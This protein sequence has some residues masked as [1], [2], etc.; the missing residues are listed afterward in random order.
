MSEV[1]TSPELFEAYTNGVTQYV[2]MVEP[3]DSS[4]DVLMIYDNTNDFQ[5]G[6][7]KI[8]SNGNN[9]TDGRA[10]MW[11]SLFDDIN[12]DNEIAIFG[13]SVWVEEY[14]EDIDGR[15]FSVTIQNRV[16]SYVLVG[17]SPPGENSRCAVFLYNEN[18]S[19]LYPLVV[20]R[21][22]DGLED[23]YWSA[24]NLNVE[25][26]NVAVELEFYVVSDDD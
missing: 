25:N 8:K 26:R 7:E 6:F 18:R 13:Y 5:K 2:D 9:K 16:E 19:L 3:S 1:L 10:L 15:S 17:D 12:Y 20:T 23:N 4:K 22:N 24:T 11:V 14:T 21:N